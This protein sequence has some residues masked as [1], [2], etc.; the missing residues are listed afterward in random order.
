M[1]KL[2]IAA[3]FLL[4]AS[5]VF[6]T[7]SASLS[8][9]DEISQ[10]RA[11]IAAKQARW[12]A[13]ETS[14]TR[15][16]PEQR[17]ARLGLIEPTGLTGLN[18]GSEV[19]TAGPYAATVPSGFDWHNV[20]EQSFVTPVRNQGGCGSCWAFA[21]TAALESSALRSSNTPGVNLNLS[22]QVLVSCGS[23]GA[24]DAGSCSGG[25]IGYASDY[26]RNTGLP[27]E[28]CYPSAGGDETRDNRTT[29]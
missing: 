21:T 18:A 20:G 5:L 15:L 23:S 17:Q 10:V 28:T 9:A 14:M 7:S 24:I 4:A 11:A 27:L 2:P 3:T 13:G 12:Q 1:R 22:E 16:S 25:Y 8:L 29:E 19:V 26:I 6:A